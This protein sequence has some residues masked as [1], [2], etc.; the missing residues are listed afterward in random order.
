[1]KENEKNRKYLQL[2]RA[3]YRQFSPFVL[4]CF[5]AYGRAAQSVIQRIAKELPIRRRKSFKADLAAAITAQLFVGNALLAQALLT[6]S[7]PTCRCR[8]RRSRG[9][10][11]RLRR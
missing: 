1:M 3:H 9:P 8:A 2:E 10:P 5:G 4:E 11:P 6:R 7:R